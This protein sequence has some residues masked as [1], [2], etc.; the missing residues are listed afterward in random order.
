M[1][2]QFK[3]FPRQV[4]D[5]ILLA[6]IFYISNR[7]ILLCSL[8]L[9]C[10]YVNAFADYILWGLVF[11]CALLLLVQSGKFLEYWLIWKANWLVILFILYSIA[12]IS[13]SI[14]P[15]RSFHTVYIMVFSSITASIFAC[16]Y[17]PKS[18]FKI[19]FSLTLIIGILSLFS[20]LLF[21]SIG[22]HQDFVWK[23]AWRGIFDH[24]NDFGPLMALGNGLALLSFLQAI[25]KQDL[26]LSF[27]SYGLTF[28]LVIMSR[29]ATAVVLIIILNGLALLYFAWMKWH[30]K[31]QSRNFYFIT[32][33][34]LATI[35]LVSLIFVVL[36]F[37]MG[38]NINL[39]GRIPLWMNL[40]NYVVS[41]KPWFGYGLETLWYFTEFQNW[42]SIVSNWG[43]VEYVVNGHNG[44]LDI[45]LYLGI[46]G[47][48]ALCLFLGRGF[49]VSFNRALIGRT[50]LDFFPLLVLAYILV[51]NLTIDYFL[52]FESFHWVIL[53]LIIFLP[54]D[55]FTQQDSEAVLQK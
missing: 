43:A 40:L 52:E 34:S 17:S 31:L 9:S 51:A 33:L 6:V 45:L 11:L 32:I 27:F 50:W 18:I 35:F 29:S 30:S 49:M 4:Y 47:L 2:Q 21:P 7:R 16:I 42:A 10:G 38:K 39:T 14:V 28:F 26:V 36:F 15:E 12:S 55:K 44:Y 53:I 24:K 1:R 41:E 37:F 20:A 54:F 48:T 13:W 19:L 25:T 46:F 5:G 23:G 8:N 22:I 3:F